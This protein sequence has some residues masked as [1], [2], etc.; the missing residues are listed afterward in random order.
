MR[1]C[2]SDARYHERPVFRKSFRWTSTRVQKKATVRTKDLI[3]RAMKLHQ[4][5]ELIAMCR[6]STTRYFVKAPAAKRIQEFTSS[7]S[8]KPTKPVKSKIEIGSTQSLETAPV[9]TKKGCTYQRNL[10]WYTQ[11]GRASR[12]NDLI[13]YG[14]H[15][16][17]S[18]MRRQQNKNKA[19][20]QP[21]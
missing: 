4:S 2:T 21:S 12:R 15:R 6:A 20:G 11:E 8:S 9:S 10:L 14:C 18:L 17:S 1:P 19:Y 13:S 16:Y 5:L 3:R 7:F